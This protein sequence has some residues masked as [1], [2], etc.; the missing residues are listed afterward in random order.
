MF[1]TFLLSLLHLL[2]D[3]VCACGMMVMSCQII[4][5]FEAY[6]LIVLYDVLAFGTQPLTG[7]WVDTCAVP[8]TKREGW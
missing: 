7:R 5:E 2:V 6:G 8:C 4:S 3:G 1:H